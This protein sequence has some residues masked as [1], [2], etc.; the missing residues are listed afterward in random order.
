MLNF[1]CIGAQKC[2]T[3]WLYETLSRHPQ[4][5]FPG[6]KEVHYWDQPGDRTVKWYLS[7]F[8]SDVH[9]NGDIT[10]A[11]AILAPD[12]I[13]SIYQALP[14][15]KLVYLIRDPIDRAWSAAK[16]ALYRAEMTHEEASDQWF[17]D[18]FMSKGSR[19]RGDY[20]TCLRRW[21]SVFPSDQLLVM[22]RDV[23]V[24]NPVQAANTILRFLGAASVFGEVEVS[25]L[26][27][28]VFEGDGQPIRPSL[29]PVL[30]DIYRNQI[31]ASEKAD[32]IGKLLSP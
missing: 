8:S 22:H 9:I 11:Y 1:L 14:Q 24:R 10:P 29:L 32:G 20:E 23:I 31:L 26:S 30:Q 6:G 21:L 4:F 28:K 13:H 5:A 2:G 25:Q 15:L 12:V 16:M 7:L 3:T 19:T 17:I 18:H 27:R